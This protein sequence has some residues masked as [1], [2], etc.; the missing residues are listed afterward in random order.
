MAR[1]LYNIEGWGAGYFDINE[2]GHVIV[3][4]DQERPERVLDLHELAIDLEEQGIALPVLLRFS[5]ILRSR[6]ETLSERFA[7]AM[8][9]FEY[10][11]RLHHRLSDQGQPAAPRRRGDRRVRPDARRRP[12]VRLEAGAA[13]GARAHRVA[14]ST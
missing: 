4:P 10:T 6:I 11:R 13:G 9:E 7:A 5:D 14:P 3:R 1:T 12:R 8:R 2:R